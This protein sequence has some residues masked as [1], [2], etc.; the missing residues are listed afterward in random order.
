[1]TSSTQKSL[2]KMRKEGYICFIVEYFNMFSRHRVDLA[3]F[4]DILCLKKDEII[5]LQCTS[6]K[7]EL[8]HIKK[9]AGHKNFNVVKESGIKIVLHSWTDKGECSIKNF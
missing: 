4:I 9:I 7:C 2:K 8:D 5:G 3:G 1:M 6:K